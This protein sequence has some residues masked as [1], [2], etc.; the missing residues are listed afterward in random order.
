MTI[1]QIQAEGED[2]E[3]E[4]T[5]VN[6]NV[7]DNECGAWGYDRAD[8]NGD[9]VVDLSEIVALYGEW[10]FCTDPYDAGI[11]TWGDCDAVWNLFAEEEE[12][13]E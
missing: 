5:I 3:L 6:F 4:E 10:L 1:V 2:G 11:E 8:L 12:E 13:E 7:Q 9:C